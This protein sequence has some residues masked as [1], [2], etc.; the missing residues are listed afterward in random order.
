MWRQGDVFIAPVA[1]IPAWA[2]RLKHGTLVEGEATGHSHRVEDL[3]TAQVFQ[4]REELYLR[5]VSDSARFNGA[6]R[7]TVELN[8][9]TGAVVQA[10]GEC[11]RPATGE[12]Q[13]AI[14]LWREAVV[15][16]TCAERLRSE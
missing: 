14:R 11:N 1:T 16:P 3:A 8:P 5:V 7:V 9:A 13:R 15:R 12:E 4:G 6:R 2:D 10:K